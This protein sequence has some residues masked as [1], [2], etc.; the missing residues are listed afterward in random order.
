MDTNA[1]EIISAATATHLA[2]IRE[3]KE[4]VARYHSGDMKDQFINEWA[5]KVKREGVFRATSLSGSSAVEHDA[6]RMQNWA[7]EL[8]SLSNCILTDPFP[9]DIR[10]AGLTETTTRTI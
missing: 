1:W 2:N 4:I 8:A 7:H 10:E 3:H 6:L 9:M 5:E